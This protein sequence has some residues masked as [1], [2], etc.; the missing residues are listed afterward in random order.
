M[1][2]AHLPRS[3]HHRGVAVANDAVVAVPGHCS[4]QDEPLHIRAAELE[5]LYRVGMRHPDDVLLDDRALVELLGHVVRRGA[6]E[7]DSTFLRLVVRTRAHER[8]E[9]GVVDV[10]DRD[11]DLVQEVR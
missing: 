8:R 2:S 1:L 10:D 11:A 5:I 7:L 9:E 6:D 4:G 3:Q